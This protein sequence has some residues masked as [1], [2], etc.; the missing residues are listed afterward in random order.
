MSAESRAGADV[1]TPEPLLDKKPSLHHI[2]EAICAPVETPVLKTPMGWTIS[3]VIAL[4]MLGIFGG[5]V[6]YLFY[7]GVGIWGN[8]QPVGW[9]W[10]ITNFV[11]WIGIGHAG[12]LI[13]AILFLFKQK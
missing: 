6:G 2:T 8:N 5:S 10:D 13:S 12:T 1:L 4:G 7:K 11:W 3:F 9:A